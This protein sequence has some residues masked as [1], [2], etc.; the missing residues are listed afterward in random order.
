MINAKKVSVRV[1]RKTDSK[2]PKTGKVFGLKVVAIDKTELKAWKE[3]T[4]KLKK[5]LPKKT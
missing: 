5:N 4:K 3:L 2:R 1:V